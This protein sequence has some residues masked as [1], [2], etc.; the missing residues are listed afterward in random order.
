MSVQQPQW[1]HGK[2]KGWNKRKNNERRNL[3]YKKLYVIVQP[4]HHNKE[5]TENTQKAER[6]IVMD[7]YGE[8]LLD[9]GF[10]ADSY[11]YIRRLLSKNVEFITYDGD[12]LRHMIWKFW[13]WENINILDLQAVFTMFYGKHKGWTDKS[14]NPFSIWQPLS[15]ALEYYDEQDNSVDLADPLDVITKTMTLHRKMKGD[16][17]L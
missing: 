4:D 16:L 11:L 8:T 13:N 7:L 9:A 17:I 1:G 15:A 12:L 5:Y 2:E 6:I 3:I 14:G 10:T